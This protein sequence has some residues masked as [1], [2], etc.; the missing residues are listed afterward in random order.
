MD[1]KNNEEPILSPEIQKLIDEIEG[2]IPEEEE[3][4]ATVSSEEVLE[5][6]EE[7]HEN[8]GEL[9]DDLRL[10]EDEYEDYDAYDWDDAEEFDEDDILDDYEESDDDLLD[11]Y[12]ESDDDLPDDYEDADDDLFGE[13]EG[14][15]ELAAYG[16][17]EADE[18]DEVIGMESIISGGKATL[19]AITENGFGKRT[20]L[21][22]YRVQ[23]RGGKGVVT[24][25]LIE[26][27]GPDHNKTY[28]TDALVDGKHLARGEGSSK[29]SAQQMAA[30]RAILKLREQM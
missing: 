9:A 6:E 14:Y 27:K 19:L 29:K 2:V 10:G 5:V 1:N 8:M 12:E 3:V 17:E 22:E 24:Y 21:D 11:D 30:Y 4:D 15:D 25:E 28:V 7:P 20:E 26:E 18:D 13:E 16:Y 23:L